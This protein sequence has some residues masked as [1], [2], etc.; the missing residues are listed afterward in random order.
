MEILLNILWMVVAL[1]A[2]AN[3]RARR[4]HHHAAHAALA[5]TCALLLLFPIISLSDDLH[6]SALYT[7][8]A[9]AKRLVAGAG[10]AVQHGMTLP[11][12]PVTLPAPAMVRRESVASAVLQVPVL[13]V[14]RT[15]PRGP[16]SPACS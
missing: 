9:P 10:H 5:L 2:I 7:E 13:V 4:S 12:A 15:D 6:G 3:W 14:P 1:L 16:P 8:E 11:V